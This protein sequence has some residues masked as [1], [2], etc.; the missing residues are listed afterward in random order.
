[1]PILAIVSLLGPLGYTYYIKYVEGMASSTSL[2]AMKDPGANQLYLFLNQ[3]WSCEYINFTILVFLALLL[4]SLLWKMLRSFLYDFWYWILIPLIA[5]LAYFNILIPL[6]DATKDQ[7]D[8]LF[9]CICFLSIDVSVIAFGKMFYKIWDDRFRSHIILERKE[10]RQKALLWAA[11]AGWSLAYLCFFIGMY[12]EGT[13]KSALAAIV[14]PAF[15]ACKMF[16]LADNINDIS[17]ELRQSGGFMSF[18]T[19]VKIIVLAITASTLIT[20]ILYRWKASLEVSI[21]RAKGKKLYVFFGITRVAQILAKDIRVKEKESIIVFVENRKEKTNLFNSV[22]FSGVLG[23]FRH[24]SEAYDIADE[25]DAHLIISNVM[26]SSPKCSELLSKKEVTSIQ[27]MMNSLGLKHFYRL[28]KDAKETH[29]FFMYDDQNINIS[30]SYNLRKLLNRTFYESDKTFHIHCWARQGAK[31]QMLEIPE[32]EYNKQEQK[33]A[34]PKKD[35]TEIDILDSSRLSIQSLLQSSENHPV[36]FVDIDTNSATVSSDFCAIIVGFGETGQDALRFIYEFGAFLDSRCAD[37]NCQLS[38]RSPF[39]CDV[40]DKDMETLRPSFLSKVPAL[41][42]T[43]A[44]YNM[45]QE[46]GKWTP[47]KHDP[48]ISF[49]TGALNS[50][51]YIQLME[52]KLTKA[53]YIVLA[54]GNDELNLRALNN[55]MSMA[56]KLRNGNL[57]YMRI[58][59]RCYSNEYSKVM[60]SQE[61]Y[62]NKMFPDAQPVK[63]FGSEKSLFSYKYVIDDDIIKKAKLFYNHY[64][65]LEYLNS[66]KDKE[67]KKKIESWEDRHNRGKKFNWKE[68]SSVKRMEHEDIHNYLHN[69][70]KKRLVSEKEDLALYAKLSSHSELIQCTNLARTEHLRWNASHEMMGYVHEKKKDE[71]KR[72]HNC[73]IPWEQLSKDYQGYDYLVVK[74]TFQNS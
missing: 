44:A 22:S 62:F 28:A 19:I 68:R 10:Q 15:S 21:E 63:M 26:M 4:A 12:S 60:E 52:M 3:P 24:R 59:V 2:D 8:I 67:I 72:T 58:F 51:A 73:L 70:T 53:N 50:D 56:V 47:N 40:I 61:S 55:L 35:Y 36:Q 42:K 25:V 11:I 5:L 18:Y 13:Q 54:L 57:K 6:T 34:S 66:N 49:H 37:V 65:W 33:E 71:V 29:C 16:F 7:V 46:Y 41:T 17:K 45:H 1:M 14:R 43:D 64:K 31:T 27:L 69:G 39:H 20:L 9:T 48:L 74:T 32:E 38:F 23:L 30:G